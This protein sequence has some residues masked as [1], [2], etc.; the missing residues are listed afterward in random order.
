MAGEMFAVILAGGSGTRLWPLSRQS[1]P[2]QMLRLLGERTMFQLTVD[3]LLPMFKPEQILVVTGR[4]HAEELMQQAPEIPRENFLVE[5]VGRNTAPAIGLAALHL[6]RRDPRACMAVLPADHY[7]RDEARF[8]AVLRAAFQVAERGFLVT[9]G[10]RPTYPATGFGYI[11][12]GELLGRFGGFLAYRVRAFREKPDLA[13]AE[14][15]VAD[16]RH[17]W[18][19]G[20][21]IWRVDRILEEIARHMPELAAGLRELEGTLGTPEE[22]EVL[23]RIW[24][25]MPNTSIDYG[26][27]EKAQEVAVIPAEF[28]WN[29]I[30]SWAA[31]LDI[32]AGDDQSNVILGAEHLGLD[33]S[34]SLIFGNGRLVATLG[35][36]DLI[37]VD[38]DDVLLVCHRERAQDVRLLVEAL[39]R[40]G[41]QEYL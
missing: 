29:D 12:R 17:S 36:R 37:I 39:K 9:L 24:P 4:E 21:F 14:R 27:M 34:G 5:P 19:S 41:R 7:I 20:M 3:R 10:I 38:T 11:E 13:T 23:R 1:R 35:V 6:R 8:R 25:G 40:E 22:G 15:F 18:N 28:G 2:K 31:L 33:T 26:V 16:G 32:L 30:G